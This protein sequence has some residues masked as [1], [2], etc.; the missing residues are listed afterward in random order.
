[1]SYPGNYVWRAT[2]HLSRK[3]RQLANCTPMWLEMRSLLLCIYVHIRLFVEKF[4][5]RVGSGLL[6][7]R[8][9]VRYMH[10]REHRPRIAHSLT[11]L[12]H[13]RGA[14]TIFNRIT[15]FL[16]CYEPPFRRV[17]KLKRVRRRF[18]EERQ[19]LSGKTSTM[20]H[21]DRKAVMPHL[22]TESSNEFFCHSFLLCYN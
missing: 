8:S 10:G 6:T 22:F 9:D 21:C 16:E 20:F 17:C 15:E 5:C 11:W 1:M 12:S 18:K 19:R 3:S 13:V 4:H 14:L 7:T 2:W